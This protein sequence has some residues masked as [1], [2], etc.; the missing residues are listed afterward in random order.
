MVGDPKAVSGATGCSPA[1]RPRR[2]PH[3]VPQV[4]SCSRGVPALQSELPAGGAGMIDKAP[5]L[6]TPDSSI[7]SGGVDPT[8]RRD[9]ASSQDSR[10]PRMPCHFRAVVAI[11]GTLRHRRPAAA[12]RRDHLAGGPEHRVRVGQRRWS[13]PS[14]VPPRPLGTAI[15]RWPTSQHGPRLRGRSADPQGQ[16][17]D[18]LQDLCDAPPLEGG[19]YTR[20]TDGAPGCLRPRIAWG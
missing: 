9:G 11:W 14:A 15:Q 13:V 10:R 7:G 4:R 16:C 6:P 5:E 18:G 19:W 1:I 20:L 8:V 17:R 12:R 3:R 2:S